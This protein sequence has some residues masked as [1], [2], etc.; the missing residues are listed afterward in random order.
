VKKKIILFSAL[1]CVVASVFTLGTSDAVFSAPVDGEDFEFKWIVPPY[2]YDSVISE[3]RIWV[4]KEKTREPGVILSEGYWTLYDIKGNIIKDNFK[5]RSISLYKNNIAYFEILGKDAI[6][7]GFINTSGDIIVPPVIKGGK[8]LLSEGLMEAAIIEEKKE[9]LDGFVDMNGNWIIAPKYDRV[10]PF[11]E[12]L[13]AVR[14]DGKY[15]Y[16][17]KTGEVVVDFIYEDAFPFSEG[18]AAVKKD[19]KYGFID[20]AGKLV[21]ECVFDY[22]SYGSGFKKGV[23]VVKI[24]S[25]YALIDK[26]GKY[27]TQPIYDNVDV[28]YYED[29]SG[30]IG[31]VKD[32]RTGFIDAKGNIVIDFKFYAIP[33]LENMPI[34]TY[35]VFRNGRAV[36][37]L[38]KV[39]ENDFELEN[40]ERGVIDEKGN[41]VFKVEHGTSLY[42]KYV[43]DYTY[44]YNYTQNKFFI[45]D[46][47]GRRYDVSSNLE[48]SMKISSCESNLFSVDNKRGMGN[49]KN[50][51]GFF[52]IV[53]KGEK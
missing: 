1:L 12:G 10:S 45:F 41:I 47:K 51:I 13:A 16:I 9:L 14:K 20:K 49:R 2:C 22:S 27:L 11:S 3:G 8:A 44:G 36:V 18:M 6:V 38:S 28:A 5:A 33:R 40:V 17:N 35:H 25:K 50:A 32:G 37:L 53:P 30:L 39:D 46:K 43:C 4:E 23:S 34:D 26:N 31:V 48:A 19:G 24:N 15:G 52:T 29:G 21:I 7:G 42:S